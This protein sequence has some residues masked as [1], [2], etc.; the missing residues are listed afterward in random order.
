MTPES[1]LPPA[2]RICPACKEPKKAEGEADPGGLR[3]PPATGE[4][5]TRAADTQA[6]GRETETEAG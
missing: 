1:A 4:T 5:R 6:A 3:S 2:R